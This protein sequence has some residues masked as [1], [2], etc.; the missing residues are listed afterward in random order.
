MVLFDPPPGYIRGGAGGRSCDMLHHMGGGPATR[1]PAPS[2][3]GGL[4]APT[5]WKRCAVAP[6]AF[7]VTN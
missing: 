4:D 3:R 1:R 7:N 6:G 2:S 5:P